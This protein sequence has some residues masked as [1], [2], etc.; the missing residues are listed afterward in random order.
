MNAR[1]AKQLTIKS[2][3]NNANTMLGKINDN[4]Q[5]CSEKGE[6][7]YCHQI[8]NACDDSNVIAEVIKILKS[9]GYEVEHRNGYD[10]RDGDS[11]NYLYINWNAP[12]N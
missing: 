8:N 5:R 2:L 7:Y 1:E 3:K 6:L 10:Q 11:W 9:D 12:S 4:I